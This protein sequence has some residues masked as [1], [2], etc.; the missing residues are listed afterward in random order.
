[1]IRIPRPDE[2][3]EQERNEIIGLYLCIA[4]RILPFDISAIIPDGAVLS[5]SSKSF[6]FHGKS[7]DITRRFTFKSKIK[8][9][10]E[11]NEPSYRS[12]INRLNQYQSPAE[13][14]QEIARMVL[15][16]IDPVLYQFLFPAGDH[17]SRENL[18]T[19]LLEPMTSPTLCS[20]RQKISEASQSSSDQPSEE[21]EESIYKK[22]FTVSDIFS[23]T[24][25][26]SH[27][28]ANELVLRLKV[29]VCP[30]CNCSLIRPMDGY[31]HAELDH[32]ISKSS[33]PEFS[34]SLLN[35]IP[36]C[37]T[38][39]HIKS[40]HDDPIFYPYAESLREENCFETRVQ[41]GVSY[42]VGEPGHEDD[43]TLCI[44]NSDSDE[45][46]VN[47]WES[48]FKLNDV[49]NH[50]RNYVLSMFYQRAVF[51]KPYLDSLCASLYKL[52]DSNNHSSEELVKVEDIKRS[53]YLRSI[54]PSD[55]LNTPLGRLTHDIDQEIERLLR[56]AETEYQ[57]SK[58]E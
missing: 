28:L 7:Y 17:V 22:F 35:L 41:N 8:E 32:Y 2:R 19:L 29:D 9:A 58:E 39:N 12:E 42:L 50:Q 6:T 47:A 51:S 53:L 56:D 43:F 30:Y 4:A 3:N 23:Y 54:Q 46:I 45:K 26:S 27:P 49:Y 33:Y 10:L 37:P 11:T 20:L 5:D 25:F 13:L 44:R 55:Y 48:V 31:R 18:Q 38:C 21:A 15:C 34:V 40:D 52:D 36:S 14:D 1:M 57:S 24:R 16:S